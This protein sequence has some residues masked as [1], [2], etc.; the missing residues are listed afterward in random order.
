[1]KGILLKHSLV[2]FIL[3]NH[4]LAQ[5]KAEEHVN[6]M[7]NCLLLGLE[8]KGLEVG[9]EIISKAEYKEVKE[10]AM[11]NLAEYFFTKSMLMNYENTTNQYVEMDKINKAYTLYIKL[12]LEFPNTRFKDIVQQ[13]IDY[14]EFNYKSRLL[15]RDLTDYLQNERTIVRKKLLFA[16][17]FL[18]REK[19]N[20]FLFF[21]KGKDPNTYELVTKYFDDIIINNPEYSIYAYYQKLLIELSRH[22]DVKI[23]S[24]IIEDSSFPTYRQSID[25]D[26]I[27]KNV[28]EILNILNNKYPNHPLTIRAYLIAVSYLIEANIWDYDGKKTKYWLELALKNDKNKLGFTYLLTKEYLLKTDFEK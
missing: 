16:D 28:L 20:E 4:L 2:L 26:S 10:T 14:L 22:Y 17:I 27:E 19:I 12:L 23:V 5:S 11:F 13:R 7:Q 6:F 8:Q 3:F 24:S 25:K 1:M 15:F 18:K 9:S 21:T